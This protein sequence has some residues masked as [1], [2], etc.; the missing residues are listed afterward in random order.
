MKRAIIVVLA[1]AA[2]AASITVTPAQS[3]ADYRLIPGIT[4]DVR[5]GGLLWDTG[6]LHVNDLQTIAYQQGT[7]AKR[8]KAGRVLVLKALRPGQPTRLG[9]LNDS[10][11]IVGTSGTRAVVWRNKSVTDLGTLPGD[12]TSTAVDVNDRGWIVGTSG[13]RAVL[14]NPSYQPQALSGAAGFT[15]VAITETNAVIGFLPSLW[16]RG[17]LPAVW[18]SGAVTRLDDTPDPDPNAPDSLVPPLAELNGGTDGLGVGSAEPAA[19][20]SYL[21][22]VQYQDG[23]RIFLQTETFGTG[24][25]C[26]TWGGAA[27]ANQSGHVTG[28]TG[29]HCE[30]GNMQA[31]A[32]V[33]DHA[34]IAA[35]LPSIGGGE[36]VYAW[37]LSDNGWVVGT[38]W[39]N[40]P[41]TADLA[42]VSVFLWHP[43]N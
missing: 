25:W 36:H 29:G 42:T 34:A 40:D 10:D 26:G 12:T 23:Q 17:V 32:V 27:A 21:Q 31:E 5:T 3:A 41:P 39:T 20:T 22:P 16:Q 37:D 1:V 8:W 24:D 38:G 18:R 43:A 28:V 35:R 7:R 33:W 14:W 4:P 9:D 30:E 2:T 11:L 19:F 6:T 15:P 13:G